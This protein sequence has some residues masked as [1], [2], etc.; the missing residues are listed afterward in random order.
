MAVP[1]TQGLEPLQSVVASDTQQ[2]TVQAG[3][4]ITASHTT[5]QSSP[6]S[7][8]SSARH[9]LSECCIASH[10]PGGT[11]VGDDVYQPF[12]VRTGNRT[13]P[14]GLGLSQ[15]APP[16]P[17]PTPS[18]QPSPPASRSSPHEQPSPAQS[19]QPSSPMSSQPAA[20]PVEQPSSPVS[21]PPPHAPQ[22]GSFISQPVFTASPEL[23][24]AIASAQA[25]QSGE[26]SLAQPQ[27]RR[28][29]TYALWRQAER[30]AAGCWRSQLHLLRHRTVCRERTAAHLFR[31]TP[32]CVLYQLAFVVT[33]RRRALASQSATDRR[34]T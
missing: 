24:A 8:R 13:L 27:R 11:A 28:S 33:I 5:L 6:D 25:A 19:S 23:C 7:L 18:S 30:A 4:P 12:V 32:A 20:S 21:C 3:R 2:Q 26:T 22:C 17:A 34:T 1:S 10:S 16:L 15:S 14:P 29:A 9:R 31:D